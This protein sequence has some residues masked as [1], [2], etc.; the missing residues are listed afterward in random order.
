MPPPAASILDANARYHDLAARHYDSKWGITYDEV[1][2]AQVTSKLRKAL[3]R[4]PG[5]F[6]RALEIG[7][8]TGYFTL[9][10]MRAGLKDDARAQFEWLVKNSKDPALTDAARRGLSRL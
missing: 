5:C 4:E 10:L 1:G 3:G 8:G 6:E 2:Q 9:N 7:A